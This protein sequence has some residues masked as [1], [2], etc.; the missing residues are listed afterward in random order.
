[1]T[2]RFS[3]CEARNMGMEKTVSF[4]G[5]PPA[6]PAV[7]DKLASEGVSVQL[8]MIDGGLAFPDEEPAAHW[9][10][11]RVA[12]EAGMV[13]IRRQESGVDLIVWG[14][15]SPELRAFWDALA[16]AFAELSS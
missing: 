13:T 2:P 15:A 3:S 6:W 12:N 7:R 16:A 14:N 9:H 4:R 5:E 11:L 10:E 8:R 1:M